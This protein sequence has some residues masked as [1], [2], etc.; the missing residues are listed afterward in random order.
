MFQGVALVPGIDGV[1]GTHFTQDDG[2]RCVTCHMQFV[3]VGAPGG[4][5]DG[6]RAAHGFRPILPGESEQVPS[7]C[8]GCHTSLATTDLV[9]LVSDTQAAVKARLDAAQTRLASLTAPADGSP[10]AERYQQAA[11][12]LDF[13]QGDGSFGVHNYKYADALLKAAESDLTALGSV[14]ATAPP[15]P[16]RTHVPSTPPPGGVTTLS[17][18]EPDQ[19]VPGGARPVTFLVIGGVIAILLVAAF[20]FFRRSGDWW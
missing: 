12:A 5:S 10:D 11:A 18:V 4:T 7:A 16:T 2:P 14:A 17:G 8:A 20:A 15:A 1:A 13:V 3:P 19:P 9:L 6:T